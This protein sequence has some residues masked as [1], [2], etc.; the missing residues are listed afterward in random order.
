[1]HVKKQMAE[2]RIIAI[3]EGSSIGPERYLDTSKYLLAYI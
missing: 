3:S 1:M 2:T